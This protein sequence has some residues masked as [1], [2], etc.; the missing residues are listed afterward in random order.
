MKL[1]IYKILERTKVEGPGIRFCIWV[2]GCSRHCKGCYAKNTWDK[3]KGKLF[4]VDDIFEKIK[5]QK[6]I[7]G[8]TFLGGE[9]FEQAEA[10]GILAQKCKGEGLSVLT[11]T[12]GTY[13]DLI[14]QNDEGINRLL[15]NTDLLIDGKFD[16]NKI[17]YS[18][19]WVGSSNQRYLFLTDRYS[20]KDVQNA[21]NKVEIHFEK[22]GKIF[23]NGMGDFNKITRDL[24]LLSD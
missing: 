22:S 9:P 5:A 20:E 18:R 1:S 6:D 12:G 21:K 3:S 7:E 8:V 13:E 17:D 14:S 15:N 24:A 23:I 10:L 4:S 16:E 2:Q 19:A 11:F